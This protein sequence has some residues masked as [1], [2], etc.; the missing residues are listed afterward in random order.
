[1][2]LTKNKTL[3]LIAG[4]VATFNLLTLKLFLKKPDR[5]QTYPGRIFR[6][7]MSLVGTDRWNSKDI[8]EIFPL[9]EGVRITIEHLPGKGVGTPIDELAYLAFI[10]KTIQPQ[11][12][13]EI[14][15]FRGRTALN[16]ALNSPDECVV[17]TLDLP[18]KSKELQQA[19][20]YPTDSEII[21]L[22]APGED[23]KGKD[24]S[25]KIIQFYGNSV[26]FDFSP[27]YGEIDLVFVDGAHHY[28]AVKSDTENA[29]KMLKPN[30]YIVWHD[31]ANFGD[32]NDVTLAIRDSVP[33]NQVVEIAN[34]QLALYHKDESNL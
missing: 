33:L 10:T 32:Y 25:H 14:G 21:Q 16:F 11:K 9:D 23:F 31:F 29:L 12:V 26:T 13:F 4:A 30:G 19:D 17:F 2:L 3:H 1:M 34:T 24:V 6:E 18:P 22:A 20:V 5:V 15:T 7:Y 8:F 27:Y 28:Q